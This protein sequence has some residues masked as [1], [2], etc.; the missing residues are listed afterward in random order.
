VTGAAGAA[1][2]LVTIVLLAYVAWGTYRL[3]IKAWWCAVAMV[4]AW[5]LSA[6]VT[7]S[8]V[9]L[10]DFYGKMNFPAEQMDLMKQMM[11]SGS[12]WMLLLMGAWVIILLGYLIYTKRFFDQQARTG[13]VTR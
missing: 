12:S 1:L 3:N 4:I 8:R 13:A 11:P 10:M 7:F 5:G 9:S 6:G 2:A